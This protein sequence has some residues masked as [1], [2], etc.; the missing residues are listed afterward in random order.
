MY[1]GGIT[2]GLSRRA[3]RFLIERAQG[4]GFPVDQGFIPYPA[5]QAARDIWTLDEA[6]IKQMARHGIVLDELQ[7]MHSEAREALVEAGEKLATYDYTGY[8]SAVRRA[9]GLEARIYPEIK[10]T[11]NDTVRAVIFYFALILPFSFFCERFFFGFPDVRRQLMGFVGFF[12]GVFL[13]LR[14]VHPA[15]KLSTSPYI[16]FLALN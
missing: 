15:F 2:P 14:W 7:A 3:V 16:I 11:A 5:L 13:I 9:L 4:R 1:H 6:R 12:V 8:Q 10:S